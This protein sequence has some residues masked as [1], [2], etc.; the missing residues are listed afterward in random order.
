MLKLK[1]LDYTITIISYSNM[2]VVSLRLTIYISHQPPPHLELPSWLT[3]RDIGSRGSSQATSETV[4]WVNWE[5]QRNLACFSEDKLK[6]WKKDPN[7]HSTHLCLG[8]YGRAFRDRAG[9]LSEITFT[10][11]SPQV[12]SKAVLGLWMVKY[13]ARQSW[14][15]EWCYFGIFQQK[16]EKDAVI[17][18][19]QETE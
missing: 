8:N 13:S 5:F 10:N 6:S 16:H 14:D 2:T 11:F 9:N 4:T 7:F 17:G 12:L 18:L 3:S 15:Y 1:K 19:I